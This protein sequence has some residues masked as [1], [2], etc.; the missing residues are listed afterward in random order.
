MYIV[1]CFLRV[2]VCHTVMITPCD[3]HCVS[4]CFSLNFV[5]LFIFFR[6]LNLTME[7]FLH[8]SFSRALESHVFRFTHQFGNFCIAFTDVLHAACIAK[9]RIERVIFVWRFYYCLGFRFVALS[10]ALSR[11]SV[12]LC[13]LVFAGAA[14]LTFLDSSVIMTT[15][16]E[17]S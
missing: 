14:Y 8:W 15:I 17:R 10:I 3:N 1:L 12:V 5:I 11:K 7:F 9:I 2:P 4:L 13:L 6:S 16:D